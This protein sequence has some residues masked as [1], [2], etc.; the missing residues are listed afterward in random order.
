[1]N[2]YF[3]KNFEELLESEIPTEAVGTTFNMMMEDASL[4]KPGH[5]K[6]VST[7][8]IA[9]DRN[10]FEL[11]NPDYS[12]SEI[13]EESKGDASQLENI[14]EDQSNASNL[15]S[16]EFE[17]KILRNNY[18]QFLGNQSQLGA[19]INEDLEG[20]VHV[21]VALAAKD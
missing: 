21:D 15:T 4:R 5:F 13:L 12:T 14:P 18:Q 9:V 20:L 17:S 7:H 8:G 1:M 3:E 11:E 19:S 6:S 10:Q 2:Q 16:Y